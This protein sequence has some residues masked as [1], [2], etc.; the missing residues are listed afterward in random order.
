MLLALFIALGL[1]MDSFAV[2][3]AC[4]AASRKNRLRH[5]AILSLSFCFF[6][7]ALAAIGWLA[8]FAFLSAIEAYDHWA[9]FIL[10]CYV[11]GK[12]IHEAAFGRKIKCGKPAGARKIVLLSLATSMDALAVGI[13][14]AFM[15]A[16]PAFYLAAI[17]AVTFALSFIGAY[18]GSC[19]RE[20]LG[21]KAEL[22]GGAVLIAI[23]VKI[24]L[25]HTGWLAAAV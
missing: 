14:F 3:I 22:L 9:A 5:A 18:F 6:Q 17:A 20:T 24:L 4:G 13:G 19:L 25:E 8:G 16:D 7:A 11:G 1:S 23:G 10:L 21:R 12:M 2:A 15:G